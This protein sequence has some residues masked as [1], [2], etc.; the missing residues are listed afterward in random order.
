MIAFL[1]LLAL[2]QIGRELSSLVAQQGRLTARVDGI[3]RALSP[4]VHD[5]IYRDEIRSSRP[6]LAAF[7]KGLGAK[8]YQD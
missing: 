7:L 3:L 4:A 6:W 5:E 8:G 2:L 1:I